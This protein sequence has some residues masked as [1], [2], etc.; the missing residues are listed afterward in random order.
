MPTKIF[1]PKKNGRP[2]SNPWPGPPNSEKTLL[3]VP[4][5]LVALPISKLTGPLGEPEYPEF[6]AE[7]SVVGDS[8]K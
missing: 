3:D 2:Q 6:V 7:N 5:R 8:Q 1:L 4:K